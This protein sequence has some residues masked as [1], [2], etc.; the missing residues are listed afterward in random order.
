MSDDGTEEG[1][2]EPDTVVAGWVAGCRE[3]MVRRA[4]HFLGDD[5][6]A[7]EMAQAACVMA[8]ERIRKDPELVER[9]M[10][11]CSWLV[12]IT[13]NVARRHL[14]D[15]ALH[16][17]LLNENKQAIGENH[18]QSSTGEWD[19]ERLVEQVL[20]VAWEVLT[21]MQLAVVKQV[22]EGKTDAETATVLTIAP[23][24]V[25]WHRAAAIHR[26]RAAMAYGK[27]D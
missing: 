2:E 27:E 10:K 9:V 11:P 14:R 20:A 16:E 23:A 6:L 8:F 19:V 1:Q 12:G 3:R 25:R 17:R 15:R 13:V 21:P 5:E 26:L 4:S 7:D 18:L 24:T 22:L